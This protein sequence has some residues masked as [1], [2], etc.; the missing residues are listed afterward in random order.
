MWSHRYG[1]AEPDC[2]AGVAVDA[3]DD[4]I[5]AGYYAGTADFGARKLVA[6]ADAEMFVARYT[7]D[8]KPRS[9]SRLSAGGESSGELYDVTVDGT[10]DA[11][12]VGGFADKLDLDTAT[13]A[14]DPAKPM[15]TFVVAFAATGRVAWSKS[16]SPGALTL[17]N[18]VAADRA[19]DIAIAGTDMNVP[20][21][22]N[23]MVSFEVATGK[24]TAGS[25]TLVIAALGPDHAPR[26]GLP[27]GAPALGDQ[28]AVAFVDRGDVVAVG[29]A[30]TMLLA[31]ATVTARTFAARIS[32]A[33]KPLWVR[34]I[35]GATDTADPVV[36]TRGAAIAIAAQTTGPVLSLL[37]PE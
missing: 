13:L 9:V 22:R 10:G 26:W 15:H 34:G 37:R 12:A 20:L 16:Y 23:G 7:P 11:I 27:V 6:K 30:Q 18:H 2:P 21:D 35:P 24:P 3:K 28:V 1:G 36:A 29:D 17:L 5:V 19:G 8:G 31:D 14:G 25:Q 33:G 4:V 32:A